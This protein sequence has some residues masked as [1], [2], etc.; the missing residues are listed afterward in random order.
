MEKLA[1]IKREHAHATSVPTSGYW[2]GPRAK[3]YG[4]MGMGIC[5]GKDN[6]DYWDHYYQQHNSHILGM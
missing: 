2:E 6:C 3:P 1:V 5:E 4:N